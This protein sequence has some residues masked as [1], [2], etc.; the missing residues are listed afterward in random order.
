M[1]LTAGRFLFDSQ[2]LTG[3]RIFTINGAGAFSEMKM[4]SISSLVARNTATSVPKLNESTYEE[5]KD[6]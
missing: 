1:T 4:G 6:L 5:S 3:H 2:N